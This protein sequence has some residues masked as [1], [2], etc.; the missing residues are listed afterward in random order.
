MKTLFL[1]CHF[2][3][4]S[5]KSFQFPFW[6]TASVLNAQ[7]VNL[8]LFQP[9]NSIAQCV[10]QTCPL[11]L[12]SL[13]SFFFFFALLM[14]NA[15]VYVVKNSKQK[16]LPLSQPYSNSITKCK[17]NLIA[18][19]I[20]FLLQGMKKMRQRNGIANR[21]QLVGWRCGQSILCHLIATVATTSIH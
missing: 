1:C 11:H 18:N 12:R 13:R 20:Q 6:Y 3:H 19:Q 5:V 16:C 10:V 17:V 15:V 8:V 4:E 7:V 2:Q 14:I 21:E 9:R